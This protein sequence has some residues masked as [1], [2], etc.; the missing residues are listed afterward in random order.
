MK[1]RFPNISHVTPFLTYVSPWFKAT[2]YLRQKG[3][4]KESIIHMLIK[5]RHKLILLIVYILKKESNHTLI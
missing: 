5:T 4:E 3:S 2:F 1:S